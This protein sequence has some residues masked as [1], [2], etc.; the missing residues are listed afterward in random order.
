MISA[1]LLVSD[2]GHLATPRGPAPLCGKR[3][4][5][6]ALVEDA[7]IACK[8]GVIV[9]VGKRKEV[10]AEVT[11]G[12]GGNRFEAGGMCAIPGYVDAH[13]H[14]PY[15]GDRLA[16]FERRLAG[17][18]YKEILDAGG[19]IHTTVAAT[20]RA[21]VEELTR[22][23]I[24]RLDRM[25]LHGTTTAEAKSG[26]GLSTESECKQ[27]EALGNA[28]EA[29]AIEIHP[30]FMGAHVIP[31]EHAA[32]REGYLR[33]LCDE[34]LPAVKARGIAKSVDVFCEKDVYSVADARRILAAAKAL[35]FSLRMHAEELEPLGG[36]ELAAELGAASAD[37]LVHVSDAGI[38]RMAH[39]SVAAVLLPGT[40]F[41]LKGRK[42]APAR[43]LVEAGAPIAIATDCNPGSSNTY[44]MANVLALA[45]L[46][47]DLSIAEALSAATLGG[48][49]AL[50]MHATHGSL[51]VGKRADF[52][53]LRVPDYRHVVYRWGENHVDT[54]VKGGQVVVYGGCLSDPTRN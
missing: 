8:D 52:Q 9:A 14:L 17:A 34:M 43:K 23:T 31:H 41:F 29:H 51:E 40:T 30:T 1:D 16:D 48:A 6:L 25:L 45:C 36:A 26:Y 46:Q 18:T 4:A 42:Y 38:E 32:D 47:M 19:G 22:L 49:F 13:T 12:R 39:A 5:D 10:E 20:R 24:S 37:H 27:L 7:A 11:L 21:S 53:L 54:V 33:L 50:H 44:A 35:G 3:L 15:A 2:I 28:S